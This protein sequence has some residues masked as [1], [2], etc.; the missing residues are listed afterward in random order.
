MKKN[1]WTDTVRLL[2]QKLV[3]PIKRSKAAPEVI[4]R[5]VGVGLAWAM[6]PLVGIQMWLVF[7]TWL[8]CKKVLKWSFSLP[9]GLAW[10][11][12]TNVFTVPPT[13]YIFYVTG[14]L[15]R[16]HWN[17]ISGYDNIRFIIAQTFMGDLSAG[18]KW[19]LVVDLMLKDWGVSM[20]IGCIP[21]VILGWIIGYHWTLKLVLHHRAKQE[22]KRKAKHV[23]FKK[24]SKR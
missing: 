15:L 11:W 17:D 18:E 13:Y 5:G 4:A 23:G 12:V 20:L 21:F 7:M 8:F 22:L 24:I 1:F 9:L 19:T 3:A 6:T 2:H 14:Q 16:G 10:T